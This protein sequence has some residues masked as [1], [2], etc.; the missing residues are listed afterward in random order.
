MAA[1][2]PWH[3]ATDVAAAPGPGAWLRIALLAAIPAVL[4]SAAIE[5]M[6]GSHILDRAVFLEAQHGGVG[7]LAGPFTRSQQHGGMLL[8]DLLYGCGVATILAGL[9][10]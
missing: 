7:A 4:L 8:A 2:S 6:I 5:L 9:L 1:T 3:R 10:V